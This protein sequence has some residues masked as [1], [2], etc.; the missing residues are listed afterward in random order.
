VTRYRRRLH[1]SWL[2]LV[3][4]AAGCSGKSQ[5]ASGATASATLPVGQ[6][7][8]SGGGVSVQVPN[9]WVTGKRTADTVLSYGSP[10]QANGQPSQSVLATLIK[11]P[12]PDLTSA[13]AARAAEVLSAV[14]GSVQLARSDMTVH[15]AGAAKLTSMSFPLPGGAT[16]TL[17][18]LVTVTA[19]K[20]E[21]VVR[22]TVQGAPNA[23]Q[24]A[25]AI[26]RTLTV[27]SSS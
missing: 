14:P 20:Q 26:L 21:L 23:A 9:T 17:Y 6:K 15:G 13:S 27:S 24:V 7:I 11:D 8:V 19:H 25:D 2:L 3:L 18:D 4:L 22:V 1:G 5:A 16:G 12:W 10:D